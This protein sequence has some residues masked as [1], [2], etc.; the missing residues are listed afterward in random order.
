VHKIEAFQKGLLGKCLVVEKGGVMRKAGIM[1]VVE[2]GGMVRPGDQ[3]QVV[4][5]EGEHK[6]LVVV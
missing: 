4:L 5:P 1:S 2:R 6:K 3:I